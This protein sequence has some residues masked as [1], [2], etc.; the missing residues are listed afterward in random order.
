MLQR[1]D[2]EIYRINQRSCEN[3]KRQKT[4]LPETLVEMCLKS[5]IK[6]RVD[7]SQNDS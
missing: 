6:G 4:D 3:D 1:R 5:I 7:G 2:S